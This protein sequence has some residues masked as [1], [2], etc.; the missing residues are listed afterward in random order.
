MRRRFRIIEH[1]ADTG[2][3]AYGR[4]LE[5]TFANAAVGM[6]SIMTDLRKVREK[7]ARVVELAEEDMEGLLFAWLNEL[8]YL[9]EVDR[10]LCRRF[11]VEELEER[12]LKAICYGEKIDLKRHNLKIGIKS[13]T[14]HLLRVDR[15]RH[16]A[17]VIFDV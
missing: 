13:A 10:L 11:V 17:R 6:F 1:T 5:E 7:E 8:I 12:R 9:F 2:L 3:V 14:Y 15:E 16:R 4:Q